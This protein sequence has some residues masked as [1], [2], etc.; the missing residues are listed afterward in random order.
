MI[1]YTG[2]TTATINKRHHNHKWQPIDDP[3]HQLLRN[4]QLTPHLVGLGSKDDEN[5]LITKRF[6]TLH[7]ILNSEIA[8]NTSLDLYVIPWQDNRQLILLNGDLIIRRW[9]PK[10]FSIEYSGTLSKNDVQNC[11]RLQ[12]RR[13]NHRRLSIRTD[14][15]S[16]IETQYSSTP[17]IETICSICGTLGLALETEIHEP[18]LAHISYGCCGQSSIMY[19]PQQIMQ[20][21]CEEWSG[22]PCSPKE[23]KRREK[24]WQRLTNSR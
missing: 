13:S 19:S 5:T 20:T 1:V 6:I 17:T 22:Q 21:R 15:Q 23:Y 14:K 4:N 3:F 16:R 18:S 24:K 8:Y 10:T 2:Y 7:P 11:R 12:I 9:N